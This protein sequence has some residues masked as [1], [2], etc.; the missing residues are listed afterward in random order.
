VLGLAGLGH[1][2][3]SS[4]QKMGFKTIAIARA[5]DKAPLARQLG[6]HHYIDSRA[7][8]PAAA[9]QKFGGA[10]VI[11]ATATSGAAMDAVQGASR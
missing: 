7:E 4:P 11:L 3:C 2:A 1:S 8:D 5:R 6:A 9:L 10:K